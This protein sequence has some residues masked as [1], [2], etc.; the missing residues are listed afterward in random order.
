MKKAILLAAALCMLTA[1]SAMAAGVNLSWTSCLA[2]SAGGLNQT[3][4]CLSNTETQ[5]K[6]FGSYVLPADADA[7][8][9]ND[10]VLDIIV[11]SATLPCWWNFTVAP[12]TAGFSMAFND[13]CG[14]AFDYWGSIGT[15]AGG[16]AA[17]LLPS[18]AVP[19]VRIKA[20]V[21]ID[22]LAAQPVP[23]ATGEIY[24][25]TFNLRHGSSFGAACTG[26]QQAACFVLNL[27]RVTQT[28]FPYMELT[29][30]HDRNFVL[31]QGGVVAPPG[32][33]LA[34]P[35]QNKTWGSVKAL[36]R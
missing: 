14:E 9:G 17:S 19:R 4:T 21:A 13:P 28:G 29:T 32:C 31:W 30:P 1:G 12:R 3:S 16:P 2:A 34:V 25:F 6:A 8:N 24:S 33:P 18:N 10:I 15:P 20:P 5:K 7:L 11:N 36:Y 27:I 22:A 23:A 26:C 35:A